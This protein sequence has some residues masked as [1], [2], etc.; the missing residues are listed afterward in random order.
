MSIDQSQIPKY[1]PPTFLE[2]S[3]SVFNKNSLINLAA[4]AIGGSAGALVFSP[5][6]VA[7]THFQS[8]LNV[9]KSS[10]HSSNPVI[11]TL[12][13]IRTLYVKEG[14]QA[15]YKG[16]GP[17]LIG[18]APSKALYFFSYSNAKLLI[19]KNESNKKIKE[20]STTHLKASALAGLITTTAMNPIW[21]IK[22]RL[23]LQNS[24]KAEYKNSI[25]CATKLIKLEGFCS[26]YKG[27]VAS[28]IGITETVLQFVIYEKLKQIELK[29]TYNSKNNRIDK[30]VNIISSAALSKLIATVVSYP[31]EVIR[32]RT[33]Q[34]T[35]NKKYSTVKKAAK[36]I[37]KEEG[38]LG[39]YGGLCP[40]L[41][42]TVPNACVV[43]GFYELVIYLLK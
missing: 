21:M 6:D 10:S 34:K 31:H 15:L 13:F 20:S 3:Q 27:L 16:I 12:G 42:R 23:Q 8:S 35:I 36:T 28:Y 7:R 19:G 40:H 14:V 32:T 9:Y 24:A 11:Q 25:D 17:T 29:G 26:L 41:M 2:T 30:S 33:R 1:I 37:L 39:F 43:F 5:L 4:G 22:T 18:V 38:I